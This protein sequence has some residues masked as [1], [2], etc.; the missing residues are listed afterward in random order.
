V[1]GA[2]NMKIA[3]VDVLHFN[4]PQVK[5]LRPIWCRIYTDEGIYGD[6]E[7]GLAY[8]VGGSAAFGMV[9]DLAALII[10]ADPLANEVIWDKLHKDTFWGQNGGPVVFAGISAIDVALW[11]IKGKYYKE[12]IY[13]LL[14]GKKRDKLRTYASQLQ[15][16]WSET[17]GPL[18]TPQD[19]AAVAKEAVEEGYDSIKVD[20]LMFDENGARFLHERQTRLLSS[21]F[22]NMVEARLAA[23][24]EAIG[25]D[26]DIIVENHSSTDALS[27]IQLGERIKKYNI[28]YYEEPATPSPKIFAELR[29]K[30][31]IPLASGE[32]IYS[33][34]QY[35][36]YFENGSLQVIQPDLCNTGG[37]TEGKKISDA[38]LV[39]DVSVQ[40]HVCGSPITV[41]AALHLETVIPNFQIHEHHFPNQLN[42]KLGLYDYQP[43]NS[44]YKAPELPGL[45]NEIS[46]FALKNSIK[47]TVE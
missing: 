9:K 14:G 45:G 33:R 11:D 34:W 19:Y 29:S 22:L 44:Y 35:A 27:A 38:A 30:L 47:A 20:F 4:D 28:F 40:P 31:D 13:K 16:G 24:R 25:P 46:E 21:D 12:P 10:G 26:V 5:G 18:R 17:R 15:F 23:T 3:K 6:G 42:R 2:E 7:A 41:A 36:P 43:E 37:I 8:G 32:R 1:K 39:Y